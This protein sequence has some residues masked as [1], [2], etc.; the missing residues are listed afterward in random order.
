M[1]KKRLFFGLDIQ[2]P[3]PE[4]LP[5]GRVLEIEHRQ[6]TLAVLGSV[7]YEKLKQK[8]PSF[9]KPAFTVGMVGKFDQPLFLPPRHPRVVAWHVQWLE[10]SNA[11]DTFLND[12]FAWLEREGFALERK[13][14]FNAH[15]TLCRSPFIVDEWKKAFSPLPLVAM[16]IHLYES[17][18]HSKYRSCWKFP[19]KPPFEELEHTGD[20]AF[21]VRGE[22]LAHLYSH[23]QVALAFIFPPLLPYLTS[24]HEQLISLQD[25]IMGLNEILSLADIDI[26]VPFK[27][28]SFHGEVCEEEDKTLSWEMIV[29]V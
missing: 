23:A 24:T 12:F 13:H 7:D 2:A 8:L 21:I 10:A 9:P 27:G 5:S 6:M 16:G 11:F 26:G 17:L 15:I 1:E 20:V 22:S 29:D 19:L 25:I 4:K 28:V 18:G 14:D 3:W